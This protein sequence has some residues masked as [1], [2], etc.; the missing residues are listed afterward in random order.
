MTQQ[1]PMNWHD[2]AELAA[3]IVQLEDLH[4]APAPSIHQPEPLRRWLLECAEM[5][6]QDWQA[7]RAE[8]LEQLA[9]GLP[10]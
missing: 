6:R 5:L 4:P 8:R 2:L 7:A 1:T 9:R 10:R 3:E